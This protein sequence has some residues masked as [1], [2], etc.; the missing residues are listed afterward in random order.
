MT[1][2]LAIHYINRISGKIEQEKV[3]GAKAL[4]FLYGDSWSSKLLGY[5][6]ALLAA[7]I[8]LISI[9][10]GWLQK[11]SF[12]KKKILPFIQTYDVDTSEFLQ[13][14]NTFTSFND[15]FIRK[16]K[17]EARPIAAGKEVAIIPADGRYYVYE[18]IA[19]VNGFVV[20]GKK[21]SL[22]SLLKDEKL[23]SRY[24]QGSM[25]MARLCPSDYHRYHFPCGCI[26]NETKLLNGPLFSVN[27]IAIRKNIDIFFEN[28]RTL[29]LLETECF[30]KV[31]YLEIGATNVGSIR[32]TY[33]PSSF[34]EKGAEKGFFEFGG[35]SLILLFE[36]G[37]I[38]FDADLLAATKQGIEIRC[39]MGQSMG[40][41]EK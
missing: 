8:P 33:H 11:S 32:Q 39:L 18:N 10:Y 7:Y 29:C 41:S 5:P 16:L 35:S 30:G 27:P 28:K 31:L 15:F 22:T 1:K 12:S 20:K 38:S 23:A 25:V 14:W 37:K 17:P 19:N 9:V 6:I 36:P 26:P 21:F 13:P 3:Y 40:T 34:Q 4:Q 2:K 24:N